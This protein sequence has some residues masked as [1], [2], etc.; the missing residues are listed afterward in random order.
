MPINIFRLYQMKVVDLTCW[1]PSLVFDWGQISNLS[2]HRG[3]MVLPYNTV[4]IA[5]FSPHMV[6]GLFTIPPRNWYSFDFIP[7]AP[8]LMMDS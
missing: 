7:G 1:V 2:I 4:P 5:A 8:S 6:V 3:A